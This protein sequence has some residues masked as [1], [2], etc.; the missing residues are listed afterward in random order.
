MYQRAMSDRPAVALLVEEQRLAAL[1]QRLV[2]VHARAVVLE[3]RLRHE[4][5]RLARRPR[6]VLDDVLVE[7]ELVGHRQ[8]RVEAHVDLGLAGGADLVVLHLDLDADALERQDHL[9]AEVLVAGPSAGRGSS[10]PC[11]AAC[12]RGSATRRARSRGPS[13]TRPRPSRRSSS[14]STGSGRSARVEDVELGLGPE[15]GGV[16][17][18]GALEVLLGLLRDV[19]RVAACTTHR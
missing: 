1:P 7:H 6:H 8:Q 2:A 9:G 17:D 10:P 13:S 16:G 3:D 14:P 4:R 11:T 12:S 19:A 15:V 5:H 18:A